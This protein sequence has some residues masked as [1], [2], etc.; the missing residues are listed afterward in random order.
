VYLWWVLVARVFSISGRIWADLRGMEPETVGIWTGWL[1]G[2]SEL[3]KV[4]TKSLF[5]GFLG[6]CRFV[7]A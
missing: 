2:V 1:S 7:T 3:F 4:L 5:P 6:V